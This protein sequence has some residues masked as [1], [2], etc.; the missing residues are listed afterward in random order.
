MFN[1]LLYLGIGI[2][3]QRFRVQGARKLCIAYFG[4]LNG[5]RP[6]I[7]PKLTSNPLTHTTLKELDEDTKKVL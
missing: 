4:S 6:P 5:G 2:F 1:A 3:N 7:M